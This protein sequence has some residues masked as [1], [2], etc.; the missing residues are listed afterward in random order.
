[1]LIHEREYF[2]NAF[3]TL[4][5]FHAMRW[6]ERYGYRRD[7]SRFLIAADTV[8]GVLYCPAII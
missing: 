2:C 6:T 1:M 5:M 4:V 3:V 7:R 8:H